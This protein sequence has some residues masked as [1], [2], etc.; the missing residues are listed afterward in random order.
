MSEKTAPDILDI[1]PVT[2]SRL[3]HIEQVTLRFQNGEV[4][5]FE[6]LKIWEPG[7]VLI[8][9]FVNAQTFLLIKEYAA[10]VN[11]YHLSF[12][13]GRIE[14]GEDIFEAAN[15]ELQEEVGYAATHLSY[16]TA[17]TSSPNYNATLTHIV[18][19]HLLTPSRLPAD[20][21]E[22]LEVIQWEVSKTDELLSRG[23]FHEARAIA[24]LY[25]AK[26]EIQNISVF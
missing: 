15:R 2:S 4:R 14:V 23:D 26:N 12:P 22:P 24:A 20:E 21:P 25:L 1:K 19:A 10:G 6:R 9:P 8:V 17:L 18:L 16:L 11:D 3:F 13:K 5:E 7:V